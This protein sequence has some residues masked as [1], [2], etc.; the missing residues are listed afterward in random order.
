MNDCVIQIQNVQELAKPKWQD[1]T[2]HQS[3]SEFFLQT[4]TCYINMNA[5]PMVF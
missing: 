3:G 4:V 2:T 5:E 1:K